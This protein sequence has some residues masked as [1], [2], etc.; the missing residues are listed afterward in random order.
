MCRA[1]PWLKSLHV[2]FTTG[3][4]ARGGFWVN[5]VGT[6]PSSYLWVPLLSRPRPPCLFLCLCQSPAPLFYAPPLPSGPALPGGCGPLTVHLRNL[7][8]P[9]LD[10]L[11]GA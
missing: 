1:E 11:L 7:A 6:Q 9:A 10:Y 8:P 4:W 2:E 3:K 5:V